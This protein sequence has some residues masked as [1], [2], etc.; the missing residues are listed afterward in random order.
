[1]SKII[2]NALK[3]TNEGSVTVHASLEGR[4]VEISVA[5]TGIGVPEDRRE[6]IFE[7]FVKLDDY[8]EGVGLG[9]PICRRLVKTLGGDIVLDSSYKKGCRFIVILP[10]K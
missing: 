10:V 8:K 3:F 5:D 7:N 1:M 4:Q 2:D 6:D 9:L